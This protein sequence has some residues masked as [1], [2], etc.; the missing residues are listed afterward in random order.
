MKPNTDRRRTKSNRSARETRTVRENELRLNKPRFTDQFVSIETDLDPVVQQSEERSDGKCRDEDR[1]ET[2]LDHWK[3]SMVNRAEKSLL[4]ISR[5][6]SKRPPK[7]IRLKSSSQRVDDFVVGID[8]RQRWYK[9]MIF[10]ST[11]TIEGQEGDHRTHGHIT[12]WMFVK[13][14][15]PKSIVLNGSESTITSSHRS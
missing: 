6:S 1:D 7:G 15:L 8:T 10:L 11:E 14:C 13:A 9:A 3:S 4:P 5:Y 2:E 12:S